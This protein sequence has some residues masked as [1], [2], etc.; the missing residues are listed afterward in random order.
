MSYNY[1]ASLNDMDALARGYDMFNIM[2]LEDAI[3]TNDI[4]IL[5]FFLESNKSKLI[6]YTNIGLKFSID[7]ELPLMMC[8][9]I[10]KSEDEDEVRNIIYKNK[11]CYSIIEVCDALIKK[12]I[13]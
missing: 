7:N 4:S 2:G 11:N 1:R 8:F 10:E 12:G 13:I 3:R 6:D 9:F 5:K